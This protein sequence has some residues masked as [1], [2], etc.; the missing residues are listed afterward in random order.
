MFSGKWITDRE[1]AALEPRNVFHRQLEP[2][3]LL[4]DEHRDC[5]ILFRK[6]FVLNELPEKAV[7]YITADDYYKLYLNGESVTQGS[8]PAYKLFSQ[9]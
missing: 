3:K 8:A 6:Q 9:S 1:F 7:L 2:K 5:H 4:C